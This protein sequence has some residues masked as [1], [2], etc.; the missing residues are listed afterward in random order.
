MKQPLQ[1][2]FRDIEHSDALENLIR[3][4]VKKLDEFNEHI[5]ACHV[6]IE[7]PHVQHKQGKLFHVSIDL[8][9]PDG[10][11]LVNRAKHPHHAHEDAYVATREAFSSL[12]RQLQDFVRKQRGKVKRHDSPSYG[13]VS[14]IFG[15]KNFGRIMTPEGR[16]IYFHRNSLVDADFDAL[17][18]GNEV[19]FSEEAGDKGPQASTVHLIGKHHIL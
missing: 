8:T 16:E 12:R 14:E 5:M 7:Q 3:E 19:R 15:E 6:V 1:I 9:M 13:K 18:I 10:E 11:I 2:T 17:E 4:K